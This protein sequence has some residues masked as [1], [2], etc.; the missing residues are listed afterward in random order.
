MGIATNGD[1]V[2]AQQ[3]LNAMHRTAPFSP[4]LPRIRRYAAAFTGSATDGDRWIE[5][6]LV[7]LIQNMEAL[8]HNGLSHNG[9]S[10]DGLP[11]D[12]LPHDG[13]TPHGAPTRL[14]DFLYVLHRTSRVDRLPPEARN[15]VAANICRLDSDIRAILLLRALE[16]LTTPDIAEII[17]C[18]EQDVE[19]MHRRGL[20][21]LRGRGALQANDKAA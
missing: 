4:L 13:P 14:T 19:A 2:C 17:G 9:L 12:G 1:K 10:H 11:H 7:S 16:D 18:R 8:P 20:A 21:A 3:Y 6:A 15:G 5:A